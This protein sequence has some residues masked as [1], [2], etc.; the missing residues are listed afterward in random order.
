MN[1]LW[2]PKHKKNCLLKLLIR[3]HCKLG[4]RKKESKMGK[5]KKKKFMWHSL[6]NRS[7]NKTAFVQSFRQFLGLFLDDLNIPRDGDLSHSNYSTTYFPFL[8]FVYICL[9]IKR[10][11]ILPCTALLLFSTRYDRNYCWKWKSSNTE[12]AKRSTSI[13]QSRLHGIFVLLNMVFEEKAKTS[14]IYRVHVFFQK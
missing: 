9:S 12:V 10:N 2:H 14:I 11:S 5:L 4:I 7:A 6:G 1:P 3:L 13:K 8:T